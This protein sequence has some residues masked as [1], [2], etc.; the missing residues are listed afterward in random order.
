MVAGAGRRV[1]A[2]EIMWRFFGRHPRR[3]E[4]AKG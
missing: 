2:N 4:V 1:D 3:G